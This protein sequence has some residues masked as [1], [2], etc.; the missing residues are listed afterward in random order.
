[1]KSTPIRVCITEPQYVAEDRGDFEYRAVLNARDTG[2]IL[3][4]PRGQRGYAVADRSEGVEHDTGAA[5]LHPFGVVPLL[6]HGPRI[7]HDDDG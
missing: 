7:A 4:H 3:V 5:L 6:R 2:A 1:M